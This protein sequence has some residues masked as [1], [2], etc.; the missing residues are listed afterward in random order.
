MEAVLCLRGIFLQLLRN[1]FN[2]AG[3]LIRRR[4][5]KE[6]THPRT[7]EKQLFLGA[8]DPYI[9]KPAFLF[10]LIVV[11]EGS[12]VREHAF[13]HPDDK[14]RWELQTFGA[15]HRHQD[16]SVT[17]VLFII[18]HTI[19]ICDKCKIREEGDKRLVLVILFKLHCH[20]QELIDI[21]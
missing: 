12:A 14:Y 6:R 5:P 20:R 16:Y 1:L 8:G 9:R 19:N 18:I 4:P 15:V 21:L 2:E 17:T 7:R 10:E 11:L 3:R 13:F